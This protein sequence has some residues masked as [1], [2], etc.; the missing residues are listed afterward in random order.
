MPTRGP[1][2]HG[3]APLRS[4]VRPP[5]S[6]SLS[7]GPGPVRV[8][9]GGA[10]PSPCDGAQ[11]PGPPRLLL[12]SP[13]SGAA[14][15]P[16]S[17]PGAGRAPAACCGEAAELVPQSLTG[18]PGGLARAPRGTRGAGACQPAAWTWRAASVPVSGRCGPASSPTPGD[19]GWGRGRVGR[20]GAEGALCRDLSAPLS[21]GQCRAGAWPSES[22]ASCGPHRRLED[23][24]ARGLRAGPLP[25]RVPAAL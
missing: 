4:L 14:V 20:R 21:R 5:R 19:R 1:Q 15:E 16:H 17:A 10:R 13:C 2:G 12:S 23:V 7:R 22:A 18:V 3:R 25:P 24:V 6:H 9:G 8:S 11:R